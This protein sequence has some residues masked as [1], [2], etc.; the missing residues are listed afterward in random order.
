MINKNYIALISTGVITVGFFTAGLLEALDLLIV[1]A[2]L[3]GALGTLILYV[4][5]M[6]STTDDSKQEN[7]Q[8]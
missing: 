2:L 4:I 6:G 3:F 5:A 1:K 7:Q 8:D